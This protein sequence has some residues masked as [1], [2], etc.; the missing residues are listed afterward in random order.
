MEICAQVYA[1]EKSSGTTKLENWVPRKLFFL[2]NYG[3]S[4][5]CRLW[6]ILNCLSLFLGSIVLLHVYVFVSNLSDKVKVKC[7]LVH[8]LRLCTGRTAHRRS[9]GIALLFLDHGTR[10]GWG[11]SVTLRPLFTPG[12]DPVPILQE[13][14][15]AP[16]PVWTDAEKYRLPPGFDPRTVQPVASRYTDYATRPTTWVIYLISQ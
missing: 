13:A 6:C 5:D 4:N 16:W 3:S 15:W 7:T 1:S 11:V 2:S 12:K 8:A 10:R 9:R 14:G